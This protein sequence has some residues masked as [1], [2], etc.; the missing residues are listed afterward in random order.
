MNICI[1]R[2]NLLRFEVH[3]NRVYQISGVN[4][5]DNLTFNLSYPGKSALMTGSIIYAN[6]LDSSD[7]VGD[8]YE[9][10][11][12]FAIATTKVTDNMMQSWLDQYSNYSQAGN[13][14]AAYG[15]FMTALTTVWLS[16]KL[17]DEMSSY[18]NVTWARCTPTAVTSGVMTN[19]AYVSCF[20]P[21]M[22]MVV[23]GNASNVF[24]FRFMCSLMLSDLEQA[25][26]ENAGLNS[27]ST[28]S[29]I[30]LG[31]MHGEHF[32]IIFDEAARTATLTLVNNSNLEMVVDLTTGLVKDIVNNGTVQY[33]GSISSDD[34]YCYHNQ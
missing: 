12:S 24:A 3:K 9:G 29:Q 7:S 8:G 34:S 30:F 16:D 18:L 1:N 4:F 27:T 6:G 14:K 11:I 23:V 19:G 21:A 28:V 26:L 22:G 32:Q 5:I 15:T 10:V 13:M 33:K 31:I 25:A 2:R 20:D 17:A